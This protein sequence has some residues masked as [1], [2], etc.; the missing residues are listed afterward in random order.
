[1]DKV[2]L[3]RQLLS[4]RQS[5]SDFDWRQKSLRICENLLTSCL[6]R[7]AETVIAYFSFRKEPDLS[8]LFSNT[9]HQ[10][11]NWGFPCCVGN[12]LVWHLWKQND[13]LAIGKYGITE[14]LADAPM[15]EAAKVDLILVPCVA[16]DYQ[17][18]RLGYGGGYYDR[19]LTMAGWQ[20][21]PTIG[22]IFGFAFLPQLPIDPWDKKLDAV[23][24]EIDFRNLSNI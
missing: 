14:P 21:K 7:Q 3:R 19:F 22:I 6:F 1:M 9:N 5:M 2:E 8:Y 15:I 16:C 4:T 12:S 23:C 13:K 24:S 20:E 11:I 17:G 10:H 18:Y